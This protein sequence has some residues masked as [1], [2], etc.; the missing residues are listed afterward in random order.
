M[1]LDPRLIECLLRA[2]ELREQGHSI[3]P[4]ELCVDCPDLIEELKRQLRV[5]GID[6]MLETPARD[7]VLGSTPQS[8]AATPGASLFR[9]GDPVSTGSTY[10][11]LRF[12]AEGSLGEVLVAQ[13]EK[14]HR[15]VALKRI[16]RRRD[17]DPQSRR[18]FLWESEITGR[19]EHPGIVPVYGWGEYGDECPFYIMRFIRGETLHE[20]IRRFHKADR[21]DRDPGERSLALRQLLTR[22]I[23]V[24]NTVGYAHSRGILHRDLKPRNIIMGRYGETLVVDW[25]LAKAFDRSPSD[26]PQ[27]EETLKPL[28]GD[29]GLGTQTG[30]VI[31]TLAYMSPEQAAGR[32]DIVGPRSDIY[33]LGATLYEVLTGVAPFSSRAAGVVDKIQRGEFAPPCQVKK[34]VP[35]P[36]AA[37]CLKAMARKP[38]D[39]YASALELAADIEHWLADEPVTAY[40]EPI[41]V[42]ASRWVRKHK[43]VVATAAAVLVTA[44]VGLAVGLF[45]VNAEKNRTEL[46]RQGEETQRIAAD[47]ARDQ[48]RHRF[49]QLRQLSKVFIFDFHDLI[50][51]L[52][53]A[54]PAR[55]LIVESALTYLDGIAQD[56]NTDLSLLRELSVAYVK[57]GDVQGNQYS[58]NLGNSA[59][60]LQS[61]EKALGIRRKLVDLDPTSKEFQRDLSS[62]YSRIADVQEMMGKHAE[63]LSNYQNAIQGDMRL[64]AS[65]PNNPI[66][67]RDLMVGHNRMGTILTSGGSSAKADLHYQEAL[68][69]AKILASRDGGSILS[70]RDLATATTHLGEMQEVRGELQAALETYKVALTISQALTAREP[71]NIQH[72]RDV[73]ITHERIGTIYFKLDFP[74][75]A[76]S[77]YERSLSLYESMARADDRNLQAKRDVMLV[78]SEIGNLHLT[79]NRLAEAELHFKKRLG[80]AE[81]LA[82]A[83]SGN[84][85][86]RVNLALVHGQLGS[87]YEKQGRLDEALQA[88]QDAQKLLSESKT[89]FPKFT[90]IRQHL[91][92]C[93][94]NIGAIQEKQGHPAEALENFIKACDLL[95][96]LEREGYVT[97]EAKLLTMGILL[98]VYRIKVKLEGPSRVDASYAECLEYGETTQKEATDNPEI[99]LGLFALYHDT[100]SYL[101]KLAADIGKT[102]VVRIEI[103]RKAGS[104][105]LCAAKPL[106]RLEATG[107]LPEGLKGALLT[108]DQQ[109]ARCKATREKLERAQ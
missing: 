9:L 72:Q 73:A 83:D 65:E 60:A 44:T 36:L 11:V 35:R 90:I 70:Q 68:R 75:K 85:D 14:L 64:S 98:R 54:T 53:G 24:S 107:G 18:R 12:H 67:L 5:L 2:E 28:S 95:K 76:L 66:F 31:G 47:R 105:Y 43:P 22:F 17:H 77:N 51:D 106:H 63:A 50:Q 100:A 32:W 27:D 55:Q 59:G 101:E 49:E 79:V 37:I 33:S 108:I 99:L 102:K 25:G 29:G 42:R 4:E 82:K 94:H 30:Y 52:Q 58:P 56:S 8:G 6:A 13:D 61:Y 87:V 89:A 7:D 19:L 23:A 91:G 84:A 45:F 80:I 97:G 21:P 46:A 41:F 92:Q 62:C 1:T 57:V 40:R 71:A 15:E 104:L 26:Q 16:Q 38:E 69:L 109:A 20:A 86:A 48:E 81:L 39:R 74:E 10:R 96:E 3:V 103:L 93:Y 34:T 88:S 78:H